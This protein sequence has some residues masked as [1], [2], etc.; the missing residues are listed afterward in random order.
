MANVHMY[1]YV[2]TYL[3]FGVGKIKEKRLPTS[4]LLTEV[5][6][7]ISDLLID[8]LIISGLNAF[9]SEPFSRS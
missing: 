1:I 8:V 3:F 9:S 4:A 7:S 2:C 6:T 5:R